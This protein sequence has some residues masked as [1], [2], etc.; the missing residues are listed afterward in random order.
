[1]DGSPDGA[2]A[3]GKGRLKFV[4]PCVDRDSSRFIAGLTGGGPTDGRQGDPY[5]S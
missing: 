5:R 2:V 3:M 4:L 1:V